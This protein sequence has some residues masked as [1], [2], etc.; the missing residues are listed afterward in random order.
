LLK[1]SKSF[2]EK[3]MKTFRR[4]CAAL[5]LTLTLALSTYAGHIPCGL[6]DEPPPP[7]SQADTTGEMATGVTGEMSTGLT[8]QM[9][10]GATAT[11]PVMET[12]LSLLQ[13]LLSL[14]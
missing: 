14:F 3:N 1:I 9:A 13:S 4:L 10:T 6:T 7:A 12:L 5:V 2:K 8:G 11:D